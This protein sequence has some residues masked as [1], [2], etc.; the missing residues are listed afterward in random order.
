M[1]TEKKVLVQIKGIRDGLLITLGN[2]EWPTLL[3]ALFQ[4]IAE[5]EA[6]FRGARVALDVG[7]QIL[8][9]AEMGSLREKLSEKGITL[10]AVL[11]NSPKTEETARLLGV[12]TRI[13]SPRP[14]R[15]LRTLNTSLDESLNAI[16][17][18]RTLRSGFKVQSPGHA[19][20]MGDVNPGSEII[21]VG[22]VIVW[23]RLKGVVH[24]GAEG[25]DQATVAALEMIPTQLRIANLVAI[26]PQQK[27]KIVPE[28]ARVHH[29]QIIVEPWDMKK[30]GGR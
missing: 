18:Q 13:F 10:W 21:A 30:E 26:P 12:A 11:S 6:F 17:V 4:H 3:D 8:K 23:G 2:G 19:I 5:R 29:G 9:A 27:G 28:V 16:L 1:I 22:N 25:D 14:E 7:D 20:V 15:E 24:A